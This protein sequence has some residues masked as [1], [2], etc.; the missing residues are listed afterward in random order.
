M[1]VALWGGLNFRVVRSSFIRRG[2]IVEIGY[3]ISL[4]LNGQNR[5]LMANNAYLMG[6]R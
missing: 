6:R 5:T 3:G 4:D 1:G 2:A